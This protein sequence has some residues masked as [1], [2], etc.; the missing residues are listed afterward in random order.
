MDSE[1]YRLDIERKMLAIM[2]KQLE[3][4]E[5]SAQR[6]KQIAQYVVDSLRPGITIAE[7]NAVV[8]YISQE[9]EEF[10]HLTVDSLNHYEDTVKEHTLEAVHKLLKE[11]KLTAAD[12]LLKKTLQED[13]ATAK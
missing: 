5:M 8:K 6:A 11:G 9:F 7:I 4:G 12:A 3:S 2:Q 1:A 10:S 13:L